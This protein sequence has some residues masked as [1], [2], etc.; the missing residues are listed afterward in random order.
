MNSL[1]RYAPR[2]LD[3]FEDFDRMFNSMFTAG[4]GYANAT[5]VVDVREEDDKYVLEAEL[6]GLSEGDV[7]V[8]LDDSLLTVSAELENKEEEKR[9]GYILR[10][11]KSRSFSRSFVLPRDVDRES[12]QASFSNGLLILELHK[13]PESKPRQ[14]E[15]KSA[16]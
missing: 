12:I 4:R 9:E 6:P 16:K 14:I 2:K 15:I 11:R 13:T 3:I 8:K 10:E 5:P 7:E 1:V